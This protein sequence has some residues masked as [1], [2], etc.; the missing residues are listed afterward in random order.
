MLHARRWRLSLWRIDHKDI[1]WLHVPRLGF[2]KATS[3]GAP[4]KHSTS[5]SS[6]VA[7]ILSC[8]T[9]AFVRMLYRC[10][11]PTYSSQA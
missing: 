8:E 2:N 7:T 1:E 5:T 6:L 3:T 11:L 10:S 9:F 4:E